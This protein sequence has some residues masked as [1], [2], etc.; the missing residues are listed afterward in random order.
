VK[1]AIF[2]SSFVDEE[3]ILSKIMWPAQGYTE[4]EFSLMSIVCPLPM[5]SN[6]FT[7]RSNNLLLA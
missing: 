6:S 7:S 1:E 5:V 4:L 3:V 2:Y